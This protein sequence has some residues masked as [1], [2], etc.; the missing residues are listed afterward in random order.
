MGQAKRRGPREARVA[1]G[2]AK[3]LQRLHAQV[4]ARVRAAG[5]E[6]AQAAAEAT[7]LELL[8]GQRRAT[9]GLP[10][11]R[12]GR[13]GLAHALVMSVLAMGDVHGD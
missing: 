10:A 5:E 13:R 4:D 2:Q 11:V 12:V 6:K 8:T 9:E 3:A 1:D 7:R